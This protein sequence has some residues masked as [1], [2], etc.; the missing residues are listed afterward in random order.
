MC[1]RDRPDGSTIIV[2]NTA[3]EPVSKT[4]SDYAGDS[5]DDT[6]QFLSLIH[7]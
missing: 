7:I 4:D 2:G 1:I 5:N 6:Q 3:A